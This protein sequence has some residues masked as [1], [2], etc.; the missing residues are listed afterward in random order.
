[1][2]LFSD[3]GSLKLI[4]ILLI[5]AIFDQSIII[6]LKANLNPSK[7]MADVE[8]KSAAETKPAEENKKEDAKEEP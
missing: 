3:F 4:F 1:M 7:A 8:M 2:S 5:Q 6:K